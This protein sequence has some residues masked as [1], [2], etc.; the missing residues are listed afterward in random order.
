MPLGKS[1]LI[2]GLAKRYRC[3]ASLTVVN[4]TPAGVAPPGQSQGGEITLTVKNRYL[5]TR[6]TSGVAPGYSV[7]F[8]G[9]L[10]LRWTHVRPSVIRLSNRCVYTVYCRLRAAARVA[11]FLERVGLLPE[12]AWRYRR[13]FSGGQRQRICIAR[14]LALKP[15]AIMPTKPFWRWMFL[16]AGR[17]S[18]CC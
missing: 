7:Y 3:V 13:Q 12:R 9:P 2:S 5:V 14:A 4:P 10:T 1:V 8:S 11:S 18:T 6:Q 15:E 17:L 16:F